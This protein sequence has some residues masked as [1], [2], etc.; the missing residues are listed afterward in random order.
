M[1]TYLPIRR[2][3]EVDTW[4]LIFKLWSDFPLLRVWSSITEPTTDTLIHFQ[5]TKAIV[6]TESPWGIPTPSGTY[7]HVAG[8]PDL[9]VVPLLAFDTYGHRVGYGGGYYDRFLADVSPKCLKIGLSYFAP[10]ERIDDVE[11]TDIRLD[12]CITPEKHYW[13]L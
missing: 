10:V 11:E 3:Q 6:L 7:E 1:H 4:P 2:Q 13:F 5:L 9:V 12:G 8:Q